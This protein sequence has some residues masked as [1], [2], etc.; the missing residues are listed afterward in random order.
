M[1][2]PGG[3]IGGSTPSS[4]EGRMPSAVTLDTCGRLRSPATLSSFHKGRPPRNEGERYPADP[5]TVEEIVAVMR[6]AGDDAAAIR[7]RGPIVVLWR[8][9]LR[10]SEALALQESDLDRSRGAV[11]V[12]RG[13]CSDRSQSAAQAPLSQTHEQNAPAEARPSAPR[14]A[15]PSPRLDQHKPSQG[16][17]T[18]GR[19]HRRPQQGCIFNRQRGVSFPPAPTQAT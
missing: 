11:L 9:G 19:L 1:A 12:R 4:E 13:T 7:L 14:Q 3:T 16:Q 6:A 5:P 17:P 10:I 2:Q 8:T 18:P 15:H